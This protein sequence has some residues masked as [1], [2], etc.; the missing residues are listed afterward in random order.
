MSE[1]TLTTRSGTRRRISPRV[2]VVVMSILGFLVIVY[3][4]TLL[5]G[6]ISGEEFAP[7]TFSRREFS[8]YQLP[9][10]HI[11]VTPVRRVVRPHELCQHL[12]KNALI[13]T[14]ATESRWDLVAARRGGRRLRDGDALILCRYLDAADA[15]GEAYWLTWSNDHPKLA[16][17][18]WPKVAQAARDELYTIVPQMFRLAWS[19]DDPLR[20]ER[21]LNAILQSNNDQS[22][23]GPAEMPLDT[24]SK[25]Q[26]EA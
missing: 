19:L 2:L 10:V 4:I 14:T 1:S 23:Q 9:V 15:E 7:D 21:D 6:S 18:L 3:F 20:L 17:V 16:K 11:Q 26:A 8:Y 5:F 24:D 22:H 13:S 12:V 25:S